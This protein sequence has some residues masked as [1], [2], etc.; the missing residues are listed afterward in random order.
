MELIRISEQKLK[1]MLTPTDMC[2]FQLG[3]D[4][5][6][7]NGE[8]MHRAFRLLLAEVRRQTD[9]EGDDRHLSVQYFPSRGGGCEMFI[10]RL[11]DDEEG[12]EAVIDSLLPSSRGAEASAPVRRQIGAFHRECAYRFDEL[13]DILRACGR[14]IGVGAVRESHA[15]RDEC[16]DYLL[17]LTV[18]S[19]SPFSI[20]EELDFLTEYG[21]IENAAL[22]RLYIREHATLIAAPD[23]IQ[24]LGAL[25]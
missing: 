2:H 4:C 11:R 12:A 18:L 14:L 22:L 10:S 20:P 9:F 25:G 17:F 1:I 7:M 3:D 8:K 21:R 6:E 19:P 15:Y 13:S 16:G 5:F 23:A 24:K